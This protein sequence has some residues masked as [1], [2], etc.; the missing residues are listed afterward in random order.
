MQHTRPS[1]RH[2]ARS[3]ALL[4]PCALCTLAAAQSATF[5][6]PGM[7]VRATATGSGQIDRFSSEFNPAIGGVIDAVADWTDRRG[8]ED[9]GLAAEVRAF[10]LSLNG[11]VDP[12]WWAY[13]TVVAADDEVAVEEAAAH[14]SGL[15]SRTT[16][17]FGRF[18]AD[19]G[20]QMQAHIH[21][22][23]Y[24]DRPGVLAEYLGEELAGVGAQ[25]DHWWPTGDA[26][27][28]RASL[29]LFTDIEGG[30]A[31]GDDEP[32]GAERTLA[33]R[34]Q[35]DEL[36]LTAR[37]TQ[38]MD[39]GERGVFQWG[40]SGR[41]LADFT[42][43]DAPN[44]LSTDGLSNTV[45]GL[46]LTYGLDSADGLSGWTF[47]G[48]YLVQ[49]GDLAAEANSG[50]TALDV[51]NDDVSGF[52]AWGERRFDTTHA[53]GLLF[54]QFEHPERGAP[55]EREVTAYLTRKHS[56]FARV[57]FALSYSDS[58]EDGDALR[59]MVQLTTFFG[60]HAH[61]VNW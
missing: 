50:L 42:F 33:E 22:L 36:A 54:S 25:V 9:D 35:L 23:P 8:S 12:D 15:D 37:V 52:Y 26:S 58:D 45:V 1:T 7:P 5:T 14:F 30:H 27:A 16:L 47:G 51:L 3:A 43:E 6:T 11:R 49:S 53:A 39:V 34:K 31:H 4:A 44:A 32:E 28:L 2:A 21:D 61:G 40:L 55:E 57:R 18:F 29:A 20:K 48:E 41:H 46:D 56:E 38:F 60:P 59:A 13:A 19:F 17:R 24:P 10:E